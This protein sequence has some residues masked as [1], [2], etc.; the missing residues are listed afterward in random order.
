[1]YSFNIA[2]HI[3]DVPE[4]WIYEH[5]LGVKKPMNGASIRMRSFINSDSNPS[6]Y[7]FVKD[8]KYKWKDYSSGT[9]GNAIEVVI[10]Q[11]G[12]SYIKAAKKVTADYNKYVQSHGKYIPLAI[13]AELSDYDMHVD[14]ELRDWN[15]N[16]RE[17]WWKQYFIPE[18]LLDYY[19]VKPLQWFQLSKQYKDRNINYQAVVRPRIYGYFRNDGS[20]YQIYQPDYLDMKFIKLNACLQGFDQLTQVSHTLIIGA[21]LKDI[22]VLESLMLN[23]ETVAPSSETSYL[24]AKDVDMFK[25]TYKHIFTM[26]DNDGPGIKAMLRYQALYGIEYIHVPFYKDIAEFAC[27]AGWDNVKREIIVRINKKINNG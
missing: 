1:M 6:L 7:L 16:D 5:Y 15:E 22:L 11:T 25:K 2:E 13:E 12:L 14:Y 21:S 23:F 19:N 10:C 26:F 3:R 4:G 8:G 17:Y 27:N 18:H 9:G 20:L 24:S